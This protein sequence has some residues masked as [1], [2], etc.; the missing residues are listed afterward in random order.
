MLALLKIGT[1]SKARR[2]WQREMSPD[3][4]FKVL[5]NEDTK[6]G[7]RNKCCAPGPMGKHLC[8]QQ[9]VRN[10]SS[11]FARALMSTEKNGCAHVL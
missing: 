8:R 7:V 9:C 4:R 1:L 3:K 10:N 2:Q 5:A 11:S 6:I